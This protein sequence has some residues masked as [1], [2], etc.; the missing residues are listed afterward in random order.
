MVVNLLIWHG[1]TDQIIPF[2]GSTS[3]HDRV[4]SL[5]LGVNDYF[6]LLLAPG[7]AHRLPGD[8]P[9]P[10]RA[11]EDLIEW[12]ERGM[13]PE[14][15]V[16]QRVEDLYVETGLLRHD[17]ERAGDRGRPLCLYPKRQEYVGGDSGVMGSYR[18]ISP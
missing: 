9:F 5:D 1:I 10:Y 4:A 18:Y 15:L 14:Q 6:R 7:T 13:A 16:A 2:G 11:M 3:Y 8:G 12:V 17:V